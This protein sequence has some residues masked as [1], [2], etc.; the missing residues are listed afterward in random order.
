MWLV[1][2]PVAGQPSGSPSSRHPGL[3][4]L[5]SPE[6]LW[7]LRAAPED[8]WPRAGQQKTGKEVEDF[9]NLFQVVVTFRLGCDLV[10]KRLC[11]S[12]CSLPDDFVSSWWYMAYISRVYSARVLLHVCSFVLC[13]PCNFVFTATSP[14]KRHPLNSSTQPVTQ[15]PPPLLLSHCTSTS[16]PLPLHYPPVPLWVASTAPRV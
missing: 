16:E 1:I 4:T 13:L 9:C 12:L 6:T 10:L 3:T 5:Q 15:P 8:E 7:Q 2:G 11:S 14:V